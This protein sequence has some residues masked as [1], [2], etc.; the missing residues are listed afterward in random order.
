LKKPYVEEVVGKGVIIYFRPVAG[1]PKGLFG[2]IRSLIGKYSVFMPNVGIENFMEKIQPNSVVSAFGYRITSVNG[3]PA[4]VETE[5]KNPLLYEIKRLNVAYKN[6]KEMLIVEKQVNRF[7]SQP[8]Y[9]KM[10]S[11]LSL[12]ENAAKA[13]TAR[14]EPYSG[15]LTITPR[16]AEEG[17]EGEY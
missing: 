16:V 1:F 9:D 10:L 15:G 8:E 12:I 17:G 5:S 7:M 11:L 6:L 3:M 13:V 2:P 14:F 4:L